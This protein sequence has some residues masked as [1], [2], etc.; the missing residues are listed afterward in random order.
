V[1]ASSLTDDLGRLQR[2]ANWFWVHIFGRTERES[3][4]Y[5][6][7]TALSRPFGHD[8]FH[9]LFRLQRGGQRAPFDIPDHLA[10]NWELS[11]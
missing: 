10:R 2:I 5:Q 6:R 3:P 11:A 9:G 7:V 4:C 8:L 1:P